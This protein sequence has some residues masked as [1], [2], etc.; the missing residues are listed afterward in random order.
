MSNN[1]IHVNQELIQT[2]LKELVRN[3]VEETAAQGIREVQAV[4]IVQNARHAECR[5]QEKCH[6][7]VEFFVLHGIAEAPFDEKK[8]EQRHKKL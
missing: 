3:S 7:K 4:D 6:E 2:E 8:I 1:I 5:Q